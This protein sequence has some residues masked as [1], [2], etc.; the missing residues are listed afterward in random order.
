MAR[1]RTIRR[2]TKRS[3]SKRKTAPLW[4]R[5]L[6]ESF[7]AFIARRFVDGFALV[8]ALGGVFT[9]LSLLSYNSQDSSWNTASDA[10]QSISN[11]MGGGGAW[12]SDILLQ[13]LGIGAVL[14]GIVFVSWGLRAFN[15]QSLSPLW[16]RTLSMLCAGIFCSIAFSQ[17]PSS[18]EWIDR[19]SVV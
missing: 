9:I 5:I 14:F 2:P 7:Q 16:L 1:T 12:L 10:N 4:T 3:K 19:K 11:W 17:I 6:P 13:T 18:G 15:R 8:S